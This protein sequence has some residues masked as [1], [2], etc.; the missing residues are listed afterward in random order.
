MTWRVRRGGHTLWT[1]MRANSRTSWLA[2]ERAHRV[3]EE[4]G[5]TEVDLRAAAANRP[6][7]LDEPYVTSDACHWLA[8]L[9]LDR[10]ACAIRQL[11]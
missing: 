10:A 6:I 11:D 2:I 5:A 7:G 3:A 9:R 4:R 1:S 8:A